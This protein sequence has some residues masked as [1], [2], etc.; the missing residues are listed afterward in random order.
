VAGT[1]AVFVVLV[2]GVVGSLWLAAVADRERA[3]AD[4]ERA[5]AD[6]ERDRAT[7]AQAAATAQRNAAIEAERRATHE[8]DR[9]LAALTRAAEAEQHAT[10][11]EDRALASDAQVRQDRDRRVWQ[12]LARE[13]IRLAGT[14][15]DDDLAALLARQ[16]FLLSRRAPDPSR[17]TLVEDALQQVSRTTTWSHR[18][19]LSSDMTGIAGAVFSP[20]GTHLATN[21]GP[22]GSMEIWDLRRPNAPPRVLKGQP[23]LRRSPFAAFSPDGTW[24]ATAGIESAAP[25]R[26]GGPVS[27]AAPVKLWDLRDS[28]PS[29]VLLHGHAREVVG[30]AFTPDGTHL[31][32]TD[33]ETMLLWDVR[34]PDAAPRVLQQTAQGPGGVPTATTMFVTFSP[35][36]SRFATRDN[37]EP[38]RSSF[39]RLWDM[40]NPIRPAAVLQGSQGALSMA[41]SPDGNQLALSCVDGVRLLDLRKPGA[42]RVLVQVPPSQG[43][44]VA[45]SRDGARLAA[46][47]PQGS[48]VYVWELGSPDASPLI[49]RGHQG[50]VLPV[51][52]SPDGSRLVSAGM[53]R[54][55]RIWEL[56]GAG[57][58]VVLASGDAALR[59]QA[60][61]FFSLSFSSD[62]SRLYGG[63]AGGEVTM[64]NH[65]RASDAPVLLRSETISDPDVVERARYGQGTQAYSP[66]GSHVAVG[67]RDIDAVRV[68]DLRERSERPLSIRKSPGRTFVRYSTDGS[69]LA[70]VNELEVRIWDL[71]NPDSSPVVIPQPPETGDVGKS[72]AFSIDN[73]W[74][75]VG[76]EDVRVYDLRQPQA[77][78]LVLRGVPGV[79]VNALAFSPD[80]HL[81]AGGNIRGTTQLWDLRNPT[82]PP[83]SLPSPRSVAA[84]LFSPDSQHL[85]ASGYDESVR[86]W[87]L[88]SAAADYLCTRV[89]RNLSMDEWRF[90]VGENIPYERTCP[91]LPPGEGAP[92]AP[93]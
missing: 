30:G 39:V 13:S 60:N 33:S 74:L 68:L 90:H 85:A 82:A 31:L 25:R 38:S 79:T 1:A 48:A 92:R 83:V 36:G 78:P 59:I 72:M 52:F 40:R 23:G 75:A 91:G 71:R 88:G 18:L 10:R 16:A 80:G 42:V 65:H 2:V 29:A 24:L 21:G 81:L 6:L 8:R 34:R 54:A 70:A 63:T 51:A 55:A 66:D 5:V 58:P 9:A 7:A 12:D 22:D 84:V 15:T 77:A 87:P 37:D 4:R 45:F 89:W 27:F 93:R 73:R 61:P 76:M 41:F 17:P 69:R 64:W 53:D 19:P 35:D 50:P 86:L 67:G 32:T 57:A 20:D 3:V 56:K 47:V 44:M 43:G 14:H 26:G 46:S 62:G 49:L 28:N 11:E